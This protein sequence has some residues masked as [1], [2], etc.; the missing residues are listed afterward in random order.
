[1]VAIASFELH[2]VDLAFNKPFKH[3]EAERA[4]SNSIFLKCVT[5]SGAFGFGE[6]LPR[7]YVTGESRDATFDT[8]RER[9]L[10][11]LIGHTFDSMDALYDFLRNCDG[12]T[13]GL[14]AASEPQTAAWCAV[15]LAL[16]DA[17]GRA[18]NAPALAAER[19]GLPGDFR[20]SGVLSADKGFT[21][22]KS[23]FKQWLF[24]L[25]AVK[26]KV[27]RVDDDAAARLLQAAESRLATHAR[28]AQGA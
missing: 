11:A 13:P 3:A 15:E 1:M 26:L 28:A 25:R 17:F 14:L 2:A 19:A 27:D 23:A 20:Y 5:D 22:F 18:F 10:P 21:L 7:K 24:G 16:L 4:A 9:I 12:K 6:C 8:L